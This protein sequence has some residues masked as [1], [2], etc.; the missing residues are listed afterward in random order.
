MTLPV[1]DAVREISDAQTLA[2]LLAERAVARELGASCH[3]PLG[4][5]AVAADRDCLRLRAWVG[6]P[7]GS[8]WASD[9]LLGHVDDPEAL[10]R[11]VA[12]AAEPGRGRRDAAPCG[13]DDE[14]WNRLSRCPGVC[15]SWAP[16][17][18]T[19]AC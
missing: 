8:A 7:D 2:C 11:D 19:R 3:T 18:A 14:G 15:I 17:R 5:W 16:G 13:G 10:G 6:L 1:A 9:E 4:A 12:V